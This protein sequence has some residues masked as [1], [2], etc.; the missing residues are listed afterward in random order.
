MDQQAIVFR[1]AVEHDQ[2]AIRALVHSERLNPTG[3]KWPNFLIALMGDRIVGAAQIRK[4]SD[5]S[6]EL[7]SLVVAKDAR[8][9]GIA[10]R[11]IDALLAE[12]RGPVWLVTPESMANI[13][14]QWGFERIE[15]A[16][17]PVKVRHN[18]RMGRMAS[19]ISFLMRRPTR[20]LV[21]LERLPTDRRKGGRPASANPVVREPL[22]VGAGL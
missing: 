11:M 7:G 6:R 16:A 10:S 20:T 1:R 22:G 19:V 12:E 21:I 15:P 14:R 17:A 13:Y 9:R 5:G 4:H 8:G 2:P 3:I 18:Y